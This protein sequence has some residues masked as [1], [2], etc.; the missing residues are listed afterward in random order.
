MIVTFGPPGISRATRSASACMP[1][2]R[3][4]SRIAALAAIVLKVTICPTLVPAVLI[5]DVADDFLTAVVGEVH[6]NIGHAHALRVEEALEE[7]LVANG[8]H[9]GDAQR[10]GHQAARRRASGDAAHAMAAGE[11]HVVPDDQEV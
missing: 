1:I 7:Q 10:V 3:P 8:V 4:T 2:T 5:G 11:V 6:V 9:V